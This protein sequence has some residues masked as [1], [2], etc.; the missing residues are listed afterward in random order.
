MKLFIWRDHLSFEIN[1]REAYC[2][3]YSRNN[4]CAC[5]AG[6]EIGAQQNEEIVGLSSGGWSCYIY[7]RSSRHKGTW[8]I[9]CAVHLS[10]FSSLN[11][12]RL[13]QFPTALYMEF[14]A[15][16]LLLFPT[17]LFYS[18]LKYFSLSFSF[19]SVHS[20]TGSWSLDFKLTIEAATLLT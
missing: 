9:F 4:E 13:S 1:H 6:K 19:D 7:F 16:F 2:T 11:C 14:V 18:F 15:H 8:I 3:I 10:C 5:G 12:Q 17:V 20:C